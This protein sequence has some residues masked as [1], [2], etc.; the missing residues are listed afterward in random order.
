MSS[1]STRRWIKRIFEAAVRSRAS[2]P[3]ARRGERPRP[4]LEHLETRIVPAP[5]PVPPGKISGLIT[6]SQEFNSTTGL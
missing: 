2:S 5:V 3:R 6:G 4:A 1:S